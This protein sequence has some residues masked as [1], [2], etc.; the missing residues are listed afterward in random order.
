MAMIEYIRKVIDV[1]IATSEMP[2]NETFLWSLVELCKF[3]GYPAVPKRLLFIYKLRDMVRYNIQIKLIQSTSNDFFANS[4]N[5]KTSK[6]RKTFV[7]LC[8]I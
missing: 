3:A 7:V 5:I 6:L 2:A 4:H 1:F 8:I